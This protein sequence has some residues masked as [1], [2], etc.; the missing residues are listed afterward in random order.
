MHFDKIGYDIRFSLQAVMEK[1]Q[2]SMLNGLSTIGSVFI[3]FFYFI[4]Y[5][6]SFF[7]F[8]KTIS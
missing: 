7:S 2:P 3:S 6:V 4:F 8:S 1:A 5:I